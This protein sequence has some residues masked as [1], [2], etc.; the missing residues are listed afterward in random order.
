MENYHVSPAQIDAWTLSEI[1]LG[2]QSLEQMDKAKNM[3]DG[4][5]LEI[6]NARKAKSNLQKL[7][8]AK[9]GE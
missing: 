5:I 8:E 9:N 4:Q 3:S 7:I 2:L 6:V 1:V